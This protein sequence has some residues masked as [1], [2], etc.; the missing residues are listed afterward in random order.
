MYYPF[1]QKLLYFFTV[2]VTPSENIIYYRACFFAAV[3]LIEVALNGFGRM[4]V[5][6]ELRTTFAKDKTM[7]HRS[8]AKP[9]G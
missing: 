3:Y 2:F 9:C 1:V 8:S 7:A 5:G 4:C 6:V